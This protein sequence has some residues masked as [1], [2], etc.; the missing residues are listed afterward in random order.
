[1]VMEVRPLQFQNASS[2]IAVTGL[3]SIT[4]GMFTV[5]ALPLYFLYGNAILPKR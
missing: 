2:P 5:A 1:M 4:A 3:P